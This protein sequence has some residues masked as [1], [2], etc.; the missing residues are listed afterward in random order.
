M[1]WEKKGQKRGKREGEVATRSI[2]A[3]RKTVPSVQFVR[4]LKLVGNLRKKI[5]KR[6]VS[7]YDSTSEEAEGVRR[8]KLTSWFEIL[9]LLFHL[10]PDR[11]PF[12]LL[13]QA[14]MLRKASHPIDLRSDEGHLVRV[15][16]LNWSVR[17]VDVD[18]RSELLPP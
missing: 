12:S 5:E 3:C 11:L 10:L 8:G 15:G 18:G 4:P 9:P 6:K 17:D 1:R 16:E 14:E 2:R 7:Y 13:D